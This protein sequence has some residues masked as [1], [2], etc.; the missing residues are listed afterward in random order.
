MVSLSWEYRGMHWCYGLPNSCTA[1]ISFPG[2]TDAISR[3][4]NGTGRKSMSRGKVLEHCLLSHAQIMFFALILLALALGFIKL[5]ILSFYRR[6]FVTN[7]G[8]TT[9]IIIKLS[10]S[11]VSLWTVA[12]VLLTTFCCGTKFAANWASVSEQLQNCPVGSTNKYGLA[13]SDLMLD[14]FIFILPLPFVSLS[15][16]RLSIR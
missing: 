14:I 1:P 12:F 3:P 7:R 11:V 6:I 4:Y 8:T 9:D 15:R 16:D 10:M 5:S 13:V 2:G